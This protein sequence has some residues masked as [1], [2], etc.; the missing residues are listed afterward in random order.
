MIK[1]N[2]NKKILK[3][4]YLANAELRKKASYERKMAKLEYV[5]QFRSKCGSY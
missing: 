4:V 5:Y 3:N 2:S 1:S